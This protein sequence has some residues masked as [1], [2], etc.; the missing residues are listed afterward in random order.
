VAALGAIARHPNLS[1]SDFK[2][3]LAADIL[4]HLRAQQTA[5]LGDFATTQAYQVVMF[6]GCFHLIVMVGLI[7][8][9]LLY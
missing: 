7:K 5:K 2:A 4:F 6:N 9:E 3:L 1:A 8:M